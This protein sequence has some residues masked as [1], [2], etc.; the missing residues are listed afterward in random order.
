MPKNN[1]NLTEREC[2]RVP[3]EI[4]IEVKKVEYPLSDDSGE[5][6]TTRDI[7]KQGICF[8]SP[9]QYEAGKMLSLNMRING[10]HRH[11]KGLTTILSDTLSEMDILTVITEVMWSKASDDHGYDIGV[12]FINVYEDDIIALEKYFSSISSDD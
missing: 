2:T 8:T 6:G 10:W 11:R 9:T 3:K 5:G 12:K 7:T 4:Q 1:K